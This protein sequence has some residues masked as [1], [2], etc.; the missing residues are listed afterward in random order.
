MRRAGPPQP[1]N[2]AGTWYLIRRVPKEFSALDERKIVRISTNIAVAN[3]PRA[4]R[5]RDVVRQLSGELEAYWRGL[6]DGQSVEARRRFEA[7]AQRARS[8]K[9]HYHTAGELAAGPLDE[10][11]RRVRLL[12]EHGALDDEQEVAAVLGGETRPALTLAGLMN[13]Y[14]ALESSSLH[15]MSPNQVKKWRNPKRRALA[16]LIAVIG[17]KPIAALTR[18]D[19]LDFR[20]WWQ[21]RLVAESLDIGT[22]NKDIGH[23][24][25]MLNAVNMAHQLN[26]NP[27]V[28][29]VATCW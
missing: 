28:Q 22:A 9:L 23:I 7:A 17:D 25:K 21:Q 14:E 26:L 6:R 2:R 5:A 13:E 29:T 20:V 11:L 24:S 1:H 4:V 19:A 12:S 3:D 10:I 15:A 16:N 18:D 8:L 27:R